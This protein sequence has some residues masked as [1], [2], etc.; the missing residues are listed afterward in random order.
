MAAL[1]TA[2]QCLA[3]PGFKGVDVAELQGAIEDASALVIDYVKPKLDDATAD[4]VPDAVRAVIIAMVRRGVTN[5]L[6]RAQET[7]GDYSY[8]QGGG[9]SS[10]VAALNMTLREKRIV[11]KAVGKL[12]AGGSDLDGWLPVQES[13]RPGGAHVDPWELV[14]E[15][16]E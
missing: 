11:R 8:S 6:A 2:E 1:V 16:E 13:E 12:G 15:N 3:R 5:P 14:E 7:L 9:G 4:D 10:G